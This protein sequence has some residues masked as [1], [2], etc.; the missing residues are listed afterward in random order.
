MARKPPT[1]EERIWRDANIDNDLKTIDA[2]LGNM[3]KSLQII[4]GRDA[5]LAQMQFKMD[6][7]EK[8]LKD[9]EST[10]TSIVKIIVGSVVTALVA[11]V[12]GVKLS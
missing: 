1:N 4:Q 10:K 3:E 5:I 2:R 7:Q 12:V 11:T 8:R 6:D 9:L